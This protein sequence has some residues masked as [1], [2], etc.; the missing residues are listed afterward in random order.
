MFTLI[1]TARIGWERIGYAVIVDDVN[2]Y[3]RIA[4]VIA[5]LDENFTEQPNL[6]ELASKVG[7]SPHHFHRLFT[8]WSG[9]TPKDFLQ[10][11]TLNR[12]KSLL[13]SGESVL[14][15]SLEAGLSGPGRLHDLCVQI[16]GASP[17]EMKTGGAG[18]VIDFG[19]SDTLF[20]PWL[21]G[22]N[23][24]G[25]CHV[26]FVEG[27]LSNSAA[28]QRLK[29]DWPRATFQRDDAVACE[30][31]AAAFVANA[32][33]KQPV[34]RA[35]VRGTAFQLRVW[36]ALLTVPPGA[37]ISY[38]RLAELS[39]AARAARAVG[40]AVGDNPLAFFIPCHRVI[41]S[42]GIIGSYRWGATRKRLL[43]GW[44]ASR[45]PIQNPCDH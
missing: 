13:I 33:L 16:E 38:G 9:V 39:G 44:E 15:A 20:G 37:L 32:S 36:R 4:S 3:Q 27:R 8:R 12:A 18:L 11:L 10:C 14:S 40:A 17:G 35:Y 42:T 21:V 30:L 41:R 28:Q 6:G 19:V 31:A 22:R 24:R 29:Q 1:I 26:S 23:A 5:Y 7:L 2:D 43:I 34:L 45:N 25:I